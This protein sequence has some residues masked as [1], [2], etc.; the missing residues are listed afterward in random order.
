M[1]DTSQRILTFDDGPNPST[2]SKILT[3]L[4]E[5]KGHATFLY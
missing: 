4:K 5:N 3:A 1:L 2:T